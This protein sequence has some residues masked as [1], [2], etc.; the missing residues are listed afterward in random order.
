MVEVSGDEEQ[1]RA[2]VRQ[3]NPLCGRKPFRPV[4]PG[5]GL[6][7]VSTGAYGVVSV[8]LLS[9]FERLYRALCRNSYWESAEVCLELSEETN[10]CL[11][12]AKEVRL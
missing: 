4:G 7:S 5:V 10:S 11:N 9:L 8:K 1:R 12:N 2:A 3:E 6:P